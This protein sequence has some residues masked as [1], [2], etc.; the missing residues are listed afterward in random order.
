MPFVLGRLLWLANSGRWAVINRT[1]HP[2][3]F[4]WAVVIW[5]LSFAGF[6]LVDLFAVAQ[7]A[8]RVFHPSGT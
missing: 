5:G 2:G 4:W 3:V 7:Q 6:V 8:A 1:N